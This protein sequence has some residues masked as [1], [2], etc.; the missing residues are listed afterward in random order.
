MFDWLLKD[1]EEKPSEAL[2]QMKAL[3][4]EADR[5][6]KLSAYLLGYAEGTL[7]SKDL[8][9]SLLHKKIRG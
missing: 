2:E 1:V 4:E 3:Y 5:L 6:E 8:L 7:G 9:V